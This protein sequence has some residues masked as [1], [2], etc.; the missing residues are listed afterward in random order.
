MLSTLAHP[1]VEVARVALAAIQA[2][3]TDRSTLCF[4]LILRAL[5]PVSKAVIEAEMMKNYE[6]QS[7]FAKKFYCQG[8]D[9][10]RA[11][12]RDEGREAGELNGTDRAIL[13][14]ARLRSV[15]TLEQLGETL[16]TK[17]DQTQL[18]VLLAAL[19]DVRA[20]SAA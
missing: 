16:A 7:A 14:L 20:G 12:G 9:E 6:F 1:T 10:G 4:D 13:L 11:R 5:D 2:L 3:P 15:P 19:A 18:E 8:S 17:V